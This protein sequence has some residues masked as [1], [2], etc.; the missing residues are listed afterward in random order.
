MHIL[1]IYYDIRTNIDYVGYVTSDMTS[2]PFVSGICPG[3]R[4]SLASSLDESDC[5]RLVIQHHETASSKSK[6]FKPISMILKFRASLW[7]IISYTIYA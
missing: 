6:S 7:K 5:V 1:V 2:F 4:N 3:F